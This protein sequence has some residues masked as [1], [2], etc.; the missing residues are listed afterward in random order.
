MFVERL[1]AESYL[2][3]NTGIACLVGSTRF[4]KDYEVANR[5]LTLKGWIVLT[6]GHF[7]H[8]LHKHLD[9]Q[10]VNA[11]A[12]QLHYYKIHL[13]D[14]VILVNDSY[15]G[16]STKRE[17]EYADSENKP[18]I[19]GSRDNEEM[20]FKCLRRHQRF[21]K[22]NRLE[23]FINTEEFQNFAKDGLGY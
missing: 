7:G 4:A 21:M 16:T 6:V 9:I 12:K 10:T 14:V 23:G 8:S 20:A 22:T 18:V 19:T 15:I 2:A 1:I 5:I 17:L 3:K 13:S 11:K